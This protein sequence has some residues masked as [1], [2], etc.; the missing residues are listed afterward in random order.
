MIPKEEEED[1]FD[2]DQ[3]ESVELV[4]FY[5][6][7]QKQNCVSNRKILKLCK[8]KYTFTNVVKQLAWFN[9]KTLSK[10]ITKKKNTRK[11]NKMNFF[12][13]KVGK[14]FIKFLKF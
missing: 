8:K 12:I 6:I 1:K 7:V 14:S 5:L 10:V 4:P 2:G 9:P 13:F 3:S 11:K